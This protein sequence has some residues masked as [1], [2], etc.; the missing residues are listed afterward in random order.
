MQINSIEDIKINY[1]ELKPKDLLFES[2]YYG[3]LAGVKLAKI[4]GANLHLGENYYLKLA[5]LYAYVDIA[6][7]LID[8]NV[9]VDYRVISQTLKNEKDDVEILE[10]LIKNGGNFEKISNYIID[11]IIYREHYNIF[12]FLIE[13]GK[14][15]EY[16]NKIKNKDIQMK[17]TLLVR[18][19]KLNT[20]TND[21]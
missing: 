15:H 19:C 7:Y 10:L 5:S 1:N 3:Y 12:L 6:K 9:K 20:I 17:A 13:N 18:K 11:D 8:N 21:K 2:V 4:K 14:L 16:I